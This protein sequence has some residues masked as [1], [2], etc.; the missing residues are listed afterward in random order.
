MFNI[1]RQYSERMDVPSRYLETVRYCLLKYYTACWCNG[2]IKDC[3]QEVVGSTLGRSTFMQQLWPNC[4]HTCASVTKQ[5][6]LVLDKGRWCSAAGKVTVGLASH[7]SCVTDSVVYVLYTQWPEKERQGDEHPAFPAVEYTAPLLY[8]IEPLCHW[9]LM[10]TTL[11]VRTVE[12]F[13][14]LWYAVVLS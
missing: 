12:N 2:L 4:S 3:D 5:Y 10:T 6:N 1:F 11:I 7:C 13:I 14:A 9:L 8:W